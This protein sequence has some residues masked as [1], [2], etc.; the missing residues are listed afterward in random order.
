MI[1]H[2]NDFIACKPLLNDCMRKGRRISVVSIDIPDKDLFEL[3]EKHKPTLTKRAANYIAANLRI[4]ES[5]LIK[6]KAETYEERLEIC[7]G[8][9]FFDAENQVCNHSNC[10]CNVPKKAILQTESCPIGKW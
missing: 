6:V 10:G 5:G 4:L 9:I 1:V 3:I 7:K 2:I 8:C